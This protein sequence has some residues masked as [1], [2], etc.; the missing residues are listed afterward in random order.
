MYLVLTALLAL[1]VS[2]EILNAF[3]TVNNSIKTA[4]GV[5]DAKNNSSYKSFDELA[6]DPKTADKARIWQPAAMEAQKV[7]SDM[8]KYINDLKN[9]LEKESG[10]NIENGVKEMNPSNLDAPS[11][12]FD[13]QGKGEELYSKL[14]A[15]KTNIL[16]V[17]NPDKFP[18]PIIKKAV[19]DK[20]A[21]LEKTLPLDLSIPKSQSGNSE[22]SFGTA[23]FHMTPS[24]AAMTILSKFQ[25]D[26]KNSEAEVVDYCLSQ[27]GSVKVVF[28][29]FAPLIGTNSTYLMPGQELEVSAGIGAFSKGA[30]PTVIINGANQPL[31]ADGMAMYKT[32]VSGAGEKSVDVKI[33]YVKPDGSTATLNKTIK[34]TVGIPSG[35]SAFLEKMNVMY[36]G[37]ENPVL[38]SAGSAGA[39]KMSVSFTGGGGSTRA[40]GDRYIFKPTNVGPAELKITV[41]GKT[42]AIPIRVKNLPDPIALVGGKKGGPIASAD[43]KAQG[44]LIARL[45]DSDFDAPFQVVSY[46]VGANG[47]SIPVYREVP[48]D[49]ARWGGGATSLINQAGPGSSI[50]FDQIRV[51]GPDGKVRELPGIYFNLR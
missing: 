20:R 34:Y 38:I 4:N 51:K 42:T 6:K 22:Q 40:G 29:E 48:N 50:F 44:G 23:Y 11:R 1:N 43:F 35:A 15:F 32:T 41:E 45:L 3:K 14:K 24:I 47:G 46:K 16:N 31:T 25:N 19:A 12:I 7:A 9:L 30:K 17:L 37:V 8:D 2:A 27:V 39:E 18:D 5:I 49:G 13:T 36:T 10:E 28:D 26:V 21:E 33:N